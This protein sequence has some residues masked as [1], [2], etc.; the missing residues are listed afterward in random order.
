MTLLRKA[1]K[2]K[3]LNAFCGLLAF[4]VVLPAFSQSLDSSKHD[5]IYHR[6]K[7]D[8][9]DIAKS[10]PYVYSRPLHW[11]KKNWIQFGSVILA[12]STVAIFDERINSYFERNQTSFQSQL[13]S[14]GDFLGQPEYQGPAVIALWGVG[15]AIKNPWMRETG[16]MLAASM[17]T[18]GIL[19]TILK[20]S[21]GRARPS[22]GKGSTEFKPF[23]GRSYHSFPSGHTMLALSTSWILARQVNYL[24]LKIVFYSI[25]PLVGWSRL[26]DN[27]H[28][29][30]D[31]VLGSA[32]GIGCAE[33]AIQYFKK[34]KK[35]NKTSS[36]IIVPNGNGASIVYNF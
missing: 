29:A 14:V 6:V 33:A 24:P 27:A 34:L 17:A 8:V 30:S 26:Y 5:N 36:L 23:G 22:F 19:Q 21:V 10:I 35:H 1:S 4:L 32:I 28:W 13:S 16:S 18:S 2:H 3:I 20:E 11:K 7:S 12:T 15:V 25:T 31:I 9:V